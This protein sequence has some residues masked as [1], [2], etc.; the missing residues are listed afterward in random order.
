MCALQIHSIDDSIITDS[1]KALTELAFARG[2]LY[3]HV[4]P[5][6]ALCSLI[7]GV[8]DPG[9]NNRCKRVVYHNHNLYLCRN[10]HFSDVL[11]SII[12]FLTFAVFCM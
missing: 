4:V 8:F 12:T 10:P 11:L 2:Q 1:S 6:L 5:L 3:R 7:H 9:L